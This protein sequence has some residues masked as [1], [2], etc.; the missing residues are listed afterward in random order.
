MLMLILSGAAW[1]RE[2]MPETVKQISAFI[3][4]TYV[5]NLLRG[6][7]NGQ[8]WGE[9]LLDVSVPT[10]IYPSYNSLTAFQHRMSM[11]NKS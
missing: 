4:L 8:P 2:L 5:V 3:P 10:I 11:I 9:H 7:W 6:L 1:P